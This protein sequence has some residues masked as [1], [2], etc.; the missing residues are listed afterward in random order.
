MKLFYRAVA[1]VYDSSSNYVADGVCG[2][3]IRIPYISAMMTD[4][5]IRLVYFDKKRTSIS[6]VIVIVYVFPVADQLLL[7]GKLQ[8]LPLTMVNT[9]TIRLTVA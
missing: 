5:R 3:V 2:L 7:N 9:V 6:N 8:I 4:D 1:K